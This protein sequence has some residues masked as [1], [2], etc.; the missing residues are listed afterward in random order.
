MSNLYANISYAGFVLGF[1]AKERHN[2]PRS[3][4][5]WR[6]T[7]SSL[8]LISIQITYADAGPTYDN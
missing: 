4:T 8:N 3:G 5:R 6:K 7:L 1:N 2:F